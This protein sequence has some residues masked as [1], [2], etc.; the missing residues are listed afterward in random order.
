MFSLLEFLFFDNTLEYEEFKYEMY[1]NN[2]N[3]YKNYYNDDS[4]VESDFS[5][6]DF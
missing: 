6:S 2:C 3:F 5:D 4:D 1:L